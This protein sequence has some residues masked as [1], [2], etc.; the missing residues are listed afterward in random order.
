MRGHKLNQ[1]ICTLYDRGADGA[2]GYSSMW[3]GTVSGEY[4]CGNLHWQSCRTI[5]PPQRSTRPFA[6][7]WKVES[8]RL[9]VENKNIIL[10]NAI[11]WINILVDAVF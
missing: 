7:Y 3:T 4:Y 2:G 8:K 6:R 5:Y 10:G 9:K 11:K 1:K